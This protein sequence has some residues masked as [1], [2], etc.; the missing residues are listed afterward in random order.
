[1]PKTGKVVVITGPSGV[2]KSTILR[3]VLRR[4]GALFSV[5][6]TTRPVRPEEVDGRDYRFVSRRTFEKM[7][8]EAELFEWA[9]VFGEYYG[10]PA[11]PVQQAM[12]DGKTMLLEIDVQGGMQV[13]EKMPEATFVLILPPGRGELKRRL[14]ARATER[15]EV[16]ESRFTRAQEEI[17]A[18]QRSGVYTH[19]VVNNDLAQAIDTVVGIVKQEQGQT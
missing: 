10:T 16:I 3:E 15:P 9:E 19:T 2:G 11:G 13:H 17:L 14:A 5:S 1:M 6:A 4:T 18:A 12:A 8:A 7:I